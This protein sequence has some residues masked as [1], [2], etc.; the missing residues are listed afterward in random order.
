MKTKPRPVKY[1]AGT[2]FAVLWAVALFGILEADFWSVKLAIGSALAS[3]SFGIDRF[4]A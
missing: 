2:C 4:L 3:A 1:L